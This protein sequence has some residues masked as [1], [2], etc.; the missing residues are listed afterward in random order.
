MKLILE[1]WRKYLIEDVSNIVYHG[2]SLGSAAAIAKKNR[3]MTSATLG[4]D[5]DE[6]G[7]RGKFY[8]LSSARLP[9]AFKE[10]FPLVKDG[11]VRLT[12]DG[13]KISQKYSGGPLD[14]WRD[15]TKGGKSEMEDRIITDEPWIEDAASYITEIVIY[16]PILKGRATDVDSMVDAIGAGKMT[17]YEYI[18]NQ[19]I[20]YPDIRDL[21]K[22]SE[23]AQ[24]NGIP[25][26]IIPTEEK[27][28][29]FYMNN[30]PSAIS[31]DEFEKLRHELNIDPAETTHRGKER[32]AFH[33]KLRNATTYS[34]LPRLS[35]V[36]AMLER[37]NLSSEGY[38]TRDDMISVKTDLYEWSKAPNFHE[39][40]PPEYEDQEK[41]EMKRKF[42]KGQIIITEQDIDDIVERLTRY[43]NE[44]PSVFAT[45]FL[46][47]RSRPDLRPYLQKFTSY[48]RK[49]K[50]KSVRELVKH[51]EERIKDD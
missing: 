20:R 49:N 43:S 46:G 21:K 4:S 47:A 1:S 29:Q 14:Y 7:N 28:N 24:S 6:I 48:M 51:L 37:G 32:D 19:S 36:V 11:K 30:Q 42:L 5:S 15:R 22:V 27:E 39:T 13:R 35:E 34:L 44:A 25:L 10:G 8:F 45:E 16:L 17:K 2:T 40:E 38:P 31:Y 26:K 12:L 41:E 33:I 3:I 9:L 50:L 18:P 23:Y